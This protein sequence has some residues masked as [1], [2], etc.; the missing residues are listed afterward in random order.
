MTPEQQELDELLKG[1]LDDTP[2]KAEVSINCLV[3]TAPTEE[4]K[5]EFAAI[6]VCNNYT[7]TAGWI[8]G[9]E[10]MRAIDLH[11]VHTMYGSC[12]LTSYYSSVHCRV[13]YKNIFVPFVH[14]HRDSSVSEN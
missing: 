6:T 11:N 9:I 10:I 2:A 5:I 1:L 13:N 14:R 3:A 8:V 4:P 12:K 7:D